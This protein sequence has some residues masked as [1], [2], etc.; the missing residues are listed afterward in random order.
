MPR[1]IRL[2]F[3]DNDGAACDLTNRIDSTV[4]RSWRQRPW[5]TNYSKWGGLHPLSPCYQA[6]PNAELLY[7]HP[8]P[9]GIGYQHW[10]G[11]LSRTRDAT[12]QVAPAI[13]TFRTRRVIDVHPGA[14]P[15]RL[16]AAGFDMDNMKARGFAESEMPVFEPRD[17]EA[18]ARQDRLVSSLVR[19]ANL[20]ATL[21]TRCVRRA[22]FS[23]GAGV[24]TDTASLA[25][26][27]ERFWSETA[28]A[29]FN[30]T[31]RAASGTD[32][33]ALNSEWHR[34]LRREASRLFAEAAPMDASGEGHPARIAAAMRQL[35]ATL[36][37][38]GKDGSEL[39]ALL[40]MAAPEAKPKK[41]RG[42]A[43]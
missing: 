19:A 1:R 41:T 35:D 21:L 7:L 22:L 36:R 24:G 31:E 18:A 28:D 25:A 37:G 5:G 14:E 16:L 6:K 15:W 2:D 29:F 26:L 40:G 17:P 12:R 27:R 20:V 9:G 39:F 38:F 4:V 13:E 32:E 10:L 11:L 33:D 43:A 30:L 3:A 8:Q 34:R 23:E 42:K